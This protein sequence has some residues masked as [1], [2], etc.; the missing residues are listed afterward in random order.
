MRPFV[1]AGVLT[2]ALFICFKTVDGAEKVKELSMPTEVGE[3]VLTIEK[4]PI[5]PNNGF[6]LKAYATDKGN[7]D[8]LGCWQEPDQLAGK[9]PNQVINIWFPEINAVASYHKKLFTP[10]LVE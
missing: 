10:R 5:E 8:H 7:P 1:I 9:P 6:P 4:C 2:T 3:V